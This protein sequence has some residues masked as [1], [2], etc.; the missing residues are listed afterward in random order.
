ML[1]FYLTT[2]YLLSRLSQT[3]CYWKS[4][5]KILPQ[6]KVVRPDKPPYC[7]FTVQKNNQDTAFVTVLL[8]KFLRYMW[9]FWSFMHA[10]GGVGKGVYTYSFLSFYTI[11]G[12]C[13]YL[14]LLPFQHSYSCVFCSVLLVCITCFEP[15][16]ATGSMR[17]PLFGCMFVCNELISE[18]APT[19]FLKLD[20]KLGD[21]KSK[22]Q[23][24]PI[25]DK[26][27]HFGRFWRNVQKMAIFAKITFFGI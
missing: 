21:N 22:K 23:H 14:V 10:W 6:Y 7:H 19:I 9:V 5:T 1:Y 25:F 15:A 13:E 12:V 20:M 2:M 27:S 17:S 3:Q 24:G 18:T 16:K 4:T 11:W 8:S 26:N